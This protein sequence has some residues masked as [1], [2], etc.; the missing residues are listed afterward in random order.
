MVSQ[1]ELGVRRP[2]INMFPKSWE[3]HIKP[4][5][6]AVYEGPLALL[7]KFNVVGGDLVAPV[8]VLVEG[9]AVGRALLRDGSW[10]AAHRQL[11]DLALREEEEDIEHTAILNYTLTSHVSEELI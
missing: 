2:R 9:D 1:I 4:T 11:L 7:F 10:R 5:S 3:Y 6:F 8:V